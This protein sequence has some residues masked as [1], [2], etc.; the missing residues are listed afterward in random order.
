[1]VLV[2]EVPEK[3]KSGTGM[4]INLPCLQ[5]RVTP[6]RRVTEIHDKAGK[7]KQNATMSSVRLLHK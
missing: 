3:P 7:P 5:V 4:K 6:A 2:V 1:M